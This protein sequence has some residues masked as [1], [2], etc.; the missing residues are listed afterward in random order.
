MKEELTPSFNDRVVTPV[1]DRFVG[2]G[3]RLTPNDYAERIHASS[4]SPATRPG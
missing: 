4:T 2:L 1:L 3:R